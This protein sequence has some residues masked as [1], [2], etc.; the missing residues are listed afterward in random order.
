LKEN[1][2]N[3]RAGNQETQ[4]SRKNHFSISRQDAKNAKGKMV[5][6]YKLQVAG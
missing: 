1:S 3:S 2:R 6:S 4:E 5:A